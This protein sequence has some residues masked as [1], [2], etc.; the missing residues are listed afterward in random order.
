MNERAQWSRSTVVPRCLIFEEVQKSAFTLSCRISRAGG[1]VAIIR[2]AAC[3]TSRLNSTEAGS[4]V[5]ARIHSPVLDFS[6]PIKNCYPCR[7]AFIAAWNPRAYQLLT[8][9]SSECLWVKE[10][11]FHVLVTLPALYSYPSQ[12]TSILQ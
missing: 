6:T 9:I 1:I 7:K 10:T 3:D 5:I 4:V 12:V 11:I 2:H 8:V